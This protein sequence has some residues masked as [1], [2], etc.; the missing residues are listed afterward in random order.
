M[1][2]TLTHKQSKKQS[3][4]SRLRNHVY[5]SRA[6]RAAQGTWTK[7][8]HDDALEMTTPE[9]E[10]EKKTIPVYPSHVSPIRPKDCSKGLRVK[11]QREKCVC[12]LRAKDIVCMCEIECF[13]ED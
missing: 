1:H 7:P 5:G 9:T 11:E 3:N 8:K 6:D 10:D 12:V 4:L 2:I 13:N